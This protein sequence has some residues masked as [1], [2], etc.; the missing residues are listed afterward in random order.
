MTKA[1]LVFGLWGILLALLLCWLSYLRVGF[2]YELSETNLTITIKWLGMRTKRTLELSSIRSVARV[3]T[4]MQLIPIGRFP[5]VW[6]TLIPA[7]MVVLR[8][9]RRL[10][11]IIITP[12][13]REAFIRAISER[14][15]AVRWDD[16]F[17][18]VLQTIRFINVSPLIMRK[19]SQ[20]V[21][22]YAAWGT[23]AGLMLFLFYEGDLWH[24]STL[25]SA[26]LLLSWWRRG[27]IRMGAREGGA[28]TARRLLVFELCFNLLAI[29][30]F[31]GLFIFSGMS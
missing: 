31:L 17:K 2:E 3:A 12:E 30:A 7:R 22:L 8:T 16:A 28:R 20:L 14:G 5:I 23:M 4:K 15:V 26:A 1:D 18:W 19:R 11:P 27:R 24:L 10:F 9:D 21:A 29:T 6:G 25:E 13:D